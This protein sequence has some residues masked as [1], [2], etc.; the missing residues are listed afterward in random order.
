M[1]TDCTD[2]ILQLAG[3]GCA[4]WAL[5]GPPGSNGAMPQRERGREMHAR[6]VEVVTRGPLC[7]DDTP[8]TIISPQ[9][10]VGKMSSLECCSLIPPPVGED[11]LMF[12]H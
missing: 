5:S 9:E 12:G 11:G 8:G 10:A 2:C 3:S 4:E 1:S 7:Y 6:Y